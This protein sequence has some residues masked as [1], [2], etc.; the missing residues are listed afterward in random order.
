M[1]I[2]RT[3][4]SCTSITLKVNLDELLVIRKNIDRLVINL[5]VIS[6]T[7]KCLRY[8]NSN[9]T[10]TSVFKN[11]TLSSHLFLLSVRNPLGIHTVSNSRKSC[12]STSKYNILLRSILYLLNKF[13]HLNS[14]VC[15]RNLK[16]SRKI[17]ASTIK[18][19]KDT[20]I[21]GV[22][23][24]LLHLSYHL[25]KS[26]NTLE[27]SL[28]VVINVNIEPLCIN[29]E[30][31]LTVK[32]LTVCVP[33]ITCKSGSNKYGVIFYNKLVLITKRT[34]L[35]F[36]KLIVECGVLPSKR[37]VSVKNIFHNSENLVLMISPT[38]P[39]ELILTENVKK[40]FSYSFVCVLSCFSV[41]KSC[42]SI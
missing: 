3:Q 12:L 36:H 42:N 23:H 8:L 24:S 40:C 10:K 37:K 31:S 33:M 39:S 21:N 14:I 32:L 6:S 19:S 4:F 18:C 26:N 22:L 5:E 17:C 34:V 11:S 41:R 35:C 9:Y 20:V 38:S 15:T 30:T 28:K 29:R 25:R 13:C 1:C 7:H 2:G 27:E 16:S